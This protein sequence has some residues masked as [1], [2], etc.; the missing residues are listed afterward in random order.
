MHTIPETVAAIM[1]P[2]HGMLVL[3]EYA[4]ALVADRGPDDAAGLAFS[5]FVLN[6]PGLDEHVSAV[7]LT[8]RS[9]ARAAARGDRSGG[10]RTGPLIGVRVPVGQRG[11]ID[12]AALEAHA[13]AGAAFAELRANLGV[14]DVARGSAY[15]EAEALARA[16]RAAQ[17]AGVLP[18]LSVALPDLPTSSIAVSQ[19]A[20]ANA[21]RA[22]RDHLA[23]HGA[24]PAHL[25]VRVSM[26][27]PGA[28]HPRQAEPAQIAH[29]TLEML[30]R[31]V[32][33][34]TPGVLLMS[35]GQSLDQACTNL[36]AIASLAAELDAPWS[37]G[38]AFSRAVLGPAAR[39]FDTHTP[40]ASRQA[41]LTA[42]RQAAEALH[43]AEAGTS[44]RS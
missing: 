3:D 25:L 5:E 10:A 34:Q 24:D 35:A 9:F 17:G 31:G 8:E 43:P 1:A 21:L 12:E 28:A 11:V 14:G 15:I 23:A 36:R 42:C 18:V 38:H 4:E 33:P 29:A 20:T 39:A 19:A 37:I 13:S 6:T 26:A 41:L 7:L 16:A 44:A 2:D 30:Q 32:A 27:R 22:L 40:A